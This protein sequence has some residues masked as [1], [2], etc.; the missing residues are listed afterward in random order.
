MVVDINDVRVGERT[1]KTIERYSQG[2]KVARI[3]LGHQKRILLAVVGNAPMI[4]LERFAETVAL[5]RTA[6]G[7]VFGY[8]KDAL[9]WIGKQFRV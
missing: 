8:M 5:N 3:Q 1:L 6:Y 2:E 7:K 9:D 4:E